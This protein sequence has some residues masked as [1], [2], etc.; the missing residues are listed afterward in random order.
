[1]SLSDPKTK[2]S[3]S[4]KSERSRI[5]IID[6]PAEIQA[7]V[8]LALTD[9]LPGIS[10]NAA[11][12]P[13][14]A[15]LLVMFSIFDEQQRSP[16]QLAEEYSEVHPRQFKALVSDAVI[17]GLKGIRSRYLELLSTA[18]EAYLD[19]VEAEGTRK[20]RQSA[21]ETMDAVRSAVGL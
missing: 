14:I 7:K 9:S 16:V 10:Y 21:G 18:Q 19:K 8:A 4:D 1:M 13:G 12:R 5:L 6:T 3:K 15:N 2:M 11:A 17:Q 20:A